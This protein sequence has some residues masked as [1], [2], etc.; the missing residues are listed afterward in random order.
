MRDLSETF[1]TLVGDSRQKRSIF[2]GKGVVWAGTNQ[3]REPLSSRQLRYGG[4]PECHEGDL[5]QQNGDL[6]QGRDSPGAGQA[7]RDGLAVVRRAE[8]TDVRFGESSDL[9]DL[10]L[11]S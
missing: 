1:V 10:K 5:L 8:Q 4:S 2:V 9:S 6:S 7:P 3:K 11:S